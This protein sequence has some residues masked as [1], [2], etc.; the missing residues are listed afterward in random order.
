VTVKKFRE[1]LVLGAICVALVQPGWGAS[2]T[3]TA[4]AGS[5]STATAPADH[6]V[7]GELVSFPGPWSFQIGRSGA[8][9]VSDE[10]LE[11][12]ADPDKKVN[13][14]LSAT[15]REQSLREICERAKAAGNRT[16]IIAFDHF[17]AQYRPGQGS[18]PRRLTPD[19]NEYVALVARISRFIEPYGL[20]LEL[21]L[22]S[23]LEIGPAYVAETGE[24][25]VWMH[26]RK[27]LRDPQ[28]GQYSVQLWRQTQW[29]NNK[30][31]IRVEDAGVRVF[32][33]REQRLH[34][35]PYIHVDP[36]SIVEITSTA[37]VEVW[38]G[39]RQHNQAFRVRVHGTGPADAP[40]LDR[41][42][43]VQSYKTPEMDYF[44]E[45]APD[46]LKALGDKYVEAG[47]K[48]NGLYSDEM[49]IQQDWGYH[50]H[51]DH[52]E[53]AVRYVSPGLARRYAEAYGEQYRDFAK[54]LIYFTC[55][56]EDFATDL[57]AKGRLMHV[58]DGSPQGIRA[59]A[60]F[61]SRY[62]RL[63]QDGVVDLF[64]G[65]KKYLEGRLGHPLEARAHAT[66]AESPTCDIWE[67]NQTRYEYTPGFLWSN[68]VHQAAAACHDYFKWG[69][70]LTGNGNDHTEGGWLDRNY[71]AIALAASTGILNEIPSSYAAHWGMP[72]EIANRR[73]ALVDASGA[74]AWAPHAI[75]QD[76]AHRDVNVL[77]L[78]PLDLVA[79]EE[80]F[81]GWMSQYAYANYVTQAK[82]LGRGKV[83]GGAIE[84]AGRRFTTLIAEFEPF[85]SR[86]LLEMMRQ[87]IDQGGRVIWSG[88]PPV[89]GAD[90]TRALEDWKNLFGVD[91]SPSNDEGVSA[92]GKLVAFERALAGIPPMTILTDFLV[93]RTYQITPRRGTD[94]AARVGNRIVGTWRALSGGGTAVVLGFRPRDDQSASLGYE[95]RWWFDIL[96]KLGAYPP[97]CLKNGHLAEVDLRSS[98]PPKAEDVNDN[99][100]YL[101]RTTDYLV[102]RFPNGAI[103]LAPHLRNLE[104]CW[105][106]GFARDAEKDKAIVAK[107]TLP[108]EQIS[109]KDFKVNGHTVSYEGQ[110]AVTFRADGNGTPI[111]FCGTN[112]N[113][114]TIDG[115]TT[116]FAHKPV[117]LISYAPLD[118]ARRV[119][120]GAVMQLMVHGAGEVRI[121]AAGLPAS[122]ELVV[123]GPTPGSRGA[124]LPC[125]V[126]NGTLIFTA[127]PGTWLYVVPLG[128]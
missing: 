19:K 114:I 60:L 53:F 9:L 14:S 58:F 32:A 103:G 74:S 116:V 66:W 123:Q 118:P 6:W 28:T 43:V 88:P 95:A 26:Y 30:G 108:S 34:G 94:P 127:G 79:V 71:Y 102:C 91:Y 27:G 85:P 68:M 8:I 55:G 11:D 62:Y 84:M 124:V 22:L 97:P 59:T 65:A 16:L 46:Y 54:W 69:D 25:G 110:R 21:S 104:E 1:F 87:L 5:T 48:L 96:S 86:Q 126:E 67:R 18:K 80:R 125:R 76:A 57:T 109:L 93:D 51:H 33:F 81:G 101:S 36:K 35:T 105:P 3:A 42:L 61:R 73:Q 2:V 90:G 20:G 47:V 113:Q 128:E 100:E 45:R 119:E 83:V 64:A 29:V 12:L 10:Q 4:P 121:P 17:F 39:S 49:H 13:L 70:F 112:T 78:Y 117:S 77:M 15:P 38:P 98:R 23:P 63:L 41:V 44:S 120:N 72:G 50:N 24:H 31:P 40:G 37:Q 82:L 89:L 75:V 106:G 111:G 107:L 122:V 99:T 7:R 115:R 56:Q 52:G 92:P